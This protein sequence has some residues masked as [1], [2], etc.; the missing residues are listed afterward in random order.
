MPHKPSMVSTSTTE[1]R[2]S[3]PLRTAPKEHAHCAHDAASSSVARK[4]LSPQYDTFGLTSENH[5][6]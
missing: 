3:S 4:P 6:D 1:V 2:S 5:Q